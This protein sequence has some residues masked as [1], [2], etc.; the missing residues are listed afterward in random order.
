VHETSNPGGHWQTGQSLPTYL[1]EI[2]LFRS[3]RVNEDNQNH[4]DRVAGKQQHDVIPRI[5]QF[6]SAAERDTRNTFV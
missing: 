6:S 1:P 2:K 5:R 3:V 4:V